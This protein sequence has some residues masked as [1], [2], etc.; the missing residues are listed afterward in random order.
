LVG[1][2]NNNDREVTPAYNEGLGAPEETDE[3]FTAVAKRNG[4][5]DYGDDES[6]EEDGAKACQHE[7]GIPLV[8]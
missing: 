1:P 5:A 2:A 3:D 6:A 8:V 4:P 7:A